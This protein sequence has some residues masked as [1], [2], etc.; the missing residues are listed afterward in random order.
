MCTKC[1]CNS[2]NKQSSGVKEW[3]NPFYI[4]S[5]GENSF[6]LRTTFRNELSSWTE[7]WLYLWN[8]HNHLHAIKFQIITFFLKDKV[9]LTTQ[10]TKFPSQRIFLFSCQ[11]PHSLQQCHQFLT[12]FSYDSRAKQNA[13]LM[14]G[15]VHWYSFWPFASQQK[16]CSIYNSEEKTCLPVSGQ[17]ESLTE[18][19]T[20]R[21]L[22]QSSFL[23][24]SSK[25]PSEMWMSVDHHEHLPNTL[26]EGHAPWDGRNWHRSHIDSSLYQHND[27]PCNT[28]QCS[29][30][31]IQISSHLASTH[32]IQ[33]KYMAVTT[34]LLLNK[35]YFCHETLF[36]TLEQNISINNVTVHPGI[37]KA[38]DNQATNRKECNR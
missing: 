18:S 37:I 12:T 27:M 24:F 21:M 19:L 34:L 10:I 28:A 7:V 6:G 30:S 17:D 35:N 14:N 22:N 29:Q 3:I 33:F 31:A 36:A 4:N 11:F 38:H 23:C 9:T 13:G 32:C 2:L 5:Y 25:I 8:V 20:W 15:V 1:C 26:R 16:Q